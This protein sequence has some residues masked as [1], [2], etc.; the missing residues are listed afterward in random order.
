[1]ARDPALR[2]HIDARLGVLK[3]QRQS[4]EPGWR[5]LSRFV[6]PRR[7]QFFSSP[8]QGGR[9]APAN[10]AILDPTALF[11]L[12]TLV[13]G[14]MAGVT[15]PAR[16]WFRLSIP[17]RRVG[18]LAPV[19]VWLDDCAERMRMVFN[20]GNAG[21]PR[22]ATA[23]GLSRR[24]PQHRHRAAGRTRTPCARNDR[25]HEHG[26]PLQR[27]GSRMGGFGRGRSRTMA[28]T[29]ET[30]TPAEQVAVARAGPG[31]EGEAAAPPA[32]AETQAGTEAAAPPPADYSGLSL[33]EGP[34][35]TQAYRWLVGLGTA[36][37]AALAYLV[38]STVKETAA[39]VDLLKVELSTV[40][41]MQTHQS[42]RIE[43]VE[44]RNDAQD[45]KL[46]SLSQQ[47]WRFSP[48]LQ[49]GSP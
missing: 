8:N 2:R 46:D 16:P 7:G 14:L 34:N 20:A 9:G 23:P 40:K 43:A 5:E 37:I 29:I 25:T 41:A 27:H 19:K 42:S 3:R 45:T 10:G 31:P 47:I 11:A 48:L 17:D 22:S 36:S 12:R 24:A 33:S 49:K 13:A 32:S 15:S 28:D 35:G 18:S 4:W 21:Q 6:N 38:L 44:R 26:S 30:T 39:G 1:M